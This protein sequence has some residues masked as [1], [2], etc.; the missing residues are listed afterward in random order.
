MRIFLQRAQV[1]LPI[2]PECELFSFLALLMFPLSSAHAG[3]ASPYA[4][5][6]E[7]I[8]ST[9]GG[10]CLA[11]AVERRRPTNLSS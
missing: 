1:L 6:R 4:R 2:S 11:G 5:Q 9:V 7:A 3:G 8:S 10:E